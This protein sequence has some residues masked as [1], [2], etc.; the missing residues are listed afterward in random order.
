MRG[1]LSA[2]E[3]KWNARKNNKVSKAFTNMYPKAKPEVINPDNF[4]EFLF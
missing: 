4:Y 3:I 2:D 1:S